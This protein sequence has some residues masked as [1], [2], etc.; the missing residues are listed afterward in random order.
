MKHSFFI[1]FLAFSIITVFV[2]C[3]KNASYQNNA[4]SQ[5]NVNNNGSSDFLAEIGLV[6]FY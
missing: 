1:V 4:D 6:I 3:Y 5:D 2:R